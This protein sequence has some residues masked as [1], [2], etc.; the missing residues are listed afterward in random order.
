MVSVPLVWC[1]P[2]PPVLAS[3]PFPIGVAPALSCFQCWWPSGCSLPLCSVACSALFSWVRA[4]HLVPFP[5]LL[6]R[7]L[8]LPFP[9]LVF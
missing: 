2:P 7:A 4:R 1:V 9:F 6:P 8:P 5:A 3:S